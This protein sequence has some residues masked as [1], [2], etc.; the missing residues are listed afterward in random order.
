[1]VVMDVGNGVLAGPGGEEGRPSSPAPAPA[2]APVIDSAPPVGPVAIAR[3]FWPYTRGFRGRVVATVVMVAVGP[4][5]TTASIW[6]FK[7]FIDDVLTPQNYR[8]FSVVAGAFLGITVAAGVVS[9]TDDYLSSWVSE[10]FMLDLRTDLFAHLHRLS[11]GFF[12]RHP[13][14]DVLSRLTGDIETVEEAVLSGLVS[15]LS[16][17]FT[18]GFYAGA[19][20]YLNWQLALAAAATAPLFLIVTRSFAGR[21]KTA[22]REKRRREGAI[23]TVAEES[24][25]NAAL[26]QA[27]DQAHGETGRFR[28]EGQG[29]FTAQM[30]TTRLRALYSPLVELLEALG[31]LVVSGL[32]LWE[33]AQHRISLGGLLVFIVYLT[34]LYSPIRGVGRE[35]NSIYAAAASAERIIELQQQQPLVP[36]AARPAQLG[37]AR[38]VLALRQVSFSYP[39]TTGAALAG[40]TFTARP[41]QTIALVGASGAGKSTLAKLLLRL[42]D[43]ERGQIYLDGYDLRQLSLSELRRNIAAVLQETLVFDATIADNIRWGKPEATQAEIEAAAVAADAHTFITAL[44]EGYDTRVGQRGRLL[45]GGQ[46][47]RVAIARALI[48]DAPILLLDEPATGLDA[49]SA[50]RVLAPLQRLMAGRT[51][52]VISHN[53]RA[54]AEADQILFLDHGRITGAGTHQQLLEDHPGYAELYHLHQHTGTPDTGAPST[55]PH[56]LG[57]VAGTGQGTTGD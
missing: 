14:G 1:M 21:I 50:Q 43:P 38:G 35:A 47:Q 16:Y 30:I 55:V 2:P 10:R 39:D 5:L 49:Q 33:L 23:T 36:D 15:T 8:L 25:S 46:R 12:E 48:R 37:R 52:I 51:T 45:S 56:R 9:Y 53:L 4:L 54:T 44:P 28:R 40:I 41:G 27:Y 42:Y 6:M 26:V 29:S 32:G 3:R 31:V 17:V 11:V 22:S 18:I 19:L 7:V 24:F 20:F 57:V 34:Q 13:L